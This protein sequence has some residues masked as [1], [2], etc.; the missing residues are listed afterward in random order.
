[1]NAQAYFNELNENEIT[2]LNPALQAIIEAPLPA[3]RAN[4]RH[5]SRKEW[6]QA[7]RK[8][9]KDMKLTEIS[10]TTPNYSMAQSISIELPRDVEAHNPVHEAAEI[11]SRKEAEYRGMVHYCPFCK[12]R[13]GAHEA[14][15][16]IILSAFPDLCDRSDTYSDH[17][18]YCLSIS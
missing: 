10:V 3:F 18:D 5:Q 11:E 1:M 13:Q 15:T 14:I 9:L 7:V 2:T 8:L 17:F 12:Q 4:I 16:A 6:A